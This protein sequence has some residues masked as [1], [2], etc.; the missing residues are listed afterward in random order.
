MLGAITTGGETGSGGEGI[1]L[2]HLHDAHTG[3]AC[4]HVP[5]SSERASAF[6]AKQKASTHSKLMH[7]ADE[8]WSWKWA[9]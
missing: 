4:S 2:T 5:V 7:S 1:G 8:I 9:R 3:L 6:L